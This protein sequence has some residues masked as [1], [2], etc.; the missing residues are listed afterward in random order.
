[1]SGTVFSE[2]SFPGVDFPGVD[3]CRMEDYEVDFY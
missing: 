3:F 1:M 2:V